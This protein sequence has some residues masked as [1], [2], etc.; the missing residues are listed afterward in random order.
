MYQGSG[1]S[2]CFALSNANANFICWAT[3]N[4]NSKRLVYM[5]LKHHHFQN[6]VFALRRFLLVLTIVIEF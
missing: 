2:L 4:S 3:K 6:G 1:Q 5:S